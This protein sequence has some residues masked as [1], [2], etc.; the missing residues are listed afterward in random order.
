MKTFMKIIAL[1]VSL[2]LVAG[3]FGC[4]TTPDVPPEAGSRT[5]IYYAASYVTAEVQ[6]AYKE[7]IKVYNETQGVIDGVYV[8]FRENAG[9]IA[10]LGMRIKALSQ[11][12]DNAE[13][14]FYI[15][16]VGVI[17]MLAEK[18]LKFFERRLTSWQEKR[19]I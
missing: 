16:V 10:G 7:M 13:M 2:V 18:I 4:K 8:Q 14:M 19:E 3:L 17:G 15:I 6:A 11:V 9:A 1:A 5:V 12:F